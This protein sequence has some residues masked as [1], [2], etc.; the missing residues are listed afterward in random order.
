MK[1]RTLVINSFI[2]PIIRYYLI[3]IGINFS[4]SYLYSIK[5]DNLD[6]KEPKT[7]NLIIKV[8]KI[9]DANLFGKLKDEFSYYMQYGHILIAAFLNEEWIGYMWI[10]LKPVKVEEL[11][12]F[13]HFDG[14]YLWKA[15]VKKDFRNKG[16]IKELLLFSFNLIKNTYKKNKAYTLVETSNTP[17]IKAIEG[18]KFSRVGTIKYNRIFLWKKYEKELDEDA[19]AFLEEKPVA[20]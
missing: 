20:L 2:L 16:I 12:R 4:K 8:C 5:L 3:K 19:L 6:L 1:N 18:S 10:S 11:D 15:Y 7:E 14:A 13:I 9:E 17:S